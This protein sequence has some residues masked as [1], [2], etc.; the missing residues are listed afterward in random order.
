VLVQIALVVFAMCAM[1]SLIIDIGYAHITQAQMQN[2]ADAAA[3]EGIRQRDAVPNPAV[4][5]AAR[6]EA[7]NTVVGWTFDDNFDPTDGDADYQFGAGPII[8]LTEGATSLHGLQTSSI[9]D[10]HV[11][12]PNLQPN[13]GNAPEGDMVSGRFCYSGDPLPSENAAYELQ[14]TVCGQP[15]R[16]AGPYTR[17]DFNPGGANPNAFL[18]RLRRSNDYQDLEG[19]TDPDVGS[20]GP[21]LPLTFG[22]AT[23]IHG[24]DPTAAY[25]VRRDGLTVRATAIAETR[26]ALHLGVPQNTAASPALAPFVLIDT[27]LQSP[28]GAPVTIPVTVNQTT[29]VMTRAN[30]QGAPPGCGPNSVVGRFIAPPAAPVPPAIST[31]IRTVGMPSPVVT[32]VTPC[33]AVPPTIATRYVAV[34]SQMTVG[35]N[36]T[37]GFARATLTRQAVCPGAG[38]GGVP[39]PFTAT[40]VRATSVVARFN[41]TAILTGGFPAALPPALVTELLDKNLGRNGAFN[42]GP[43]LVPV[44]AR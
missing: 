35:P 18:V 11:Y 36:R 8:D 29:G 28:A 43:V 40:I 12:K 20:S 44:L 7:A 41:A 31:A 39:P 30:A 5:D 9:P 16:G 4:A 3:I 1:L 10:V 42:Y 19:Q 17:N 23:T 2:A 14:D 25:S 33:Q 37:I 15:Q 6:R 34:Y 27:C 32:T 38:R 24:D 26:P 13:L 22:K 21:A